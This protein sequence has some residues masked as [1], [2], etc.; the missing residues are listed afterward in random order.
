MKL[1]AAVVCSVIATALAVPPA[2]AVG[3]GQ[4]TKVVCVSSKTSHRVYRKKPKSCAFHRHG[5]PL[6]E[7]F[8]V[9]TTHDQWRMWHRGHAR[10][11]GR[12]VTSM[13]H[14]HPPVRIRLSHPVNRCGHRVFSRA[15]F[16]F[17]KVGR[18]STMRL[19]ACA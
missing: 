13:G 19:D 14:T 7:A 1:G 9:R 16:F 10:G 12:E 5:E 15:H 4:G 11:K 8:M 6:A 2:V 3:K 18:G 17:P